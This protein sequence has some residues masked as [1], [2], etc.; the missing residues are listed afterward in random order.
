[1]ERPIEPRVLFVP[2]FMQRG[3]AWRPVAERIEPS[4]HAV[5]LDH[6]RA[7]FS[8]RIEEILE[9]MAPGT[10]LVGYSMGGRLAVHAALRRPRSLTALVLV[11][12]S[13]G[14]EDPGA[15]E[16]RRSADERL[17]AWMES[18]SIEEIVA[19]WESLP[20]F[21]SQSRELRESLRPGRLSH[22]P[23][24]LAM[25]LRTV[26]QGALPP[27]WDRLGEIAC[28]ALFVAGE[29]DDAYVQVAYRMSESVPNGRARLIP[30]AGHAPQLERP[31]AFAEV[32]VEFLR[33][34][35]AASRA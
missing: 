33:D 2:G 28:P 12:A 22:D 16:D 5:C 30:G 29:G 13:A 18:H 10:A 3:D 26:G 8:G 15:R 32:L 1:V 21:A 35:T 7:T 27:V 11:G 24:E 25:L 6:R 17:A 23:A 19:A 34:A 20:V 31:K 9:A 14:I 4:H